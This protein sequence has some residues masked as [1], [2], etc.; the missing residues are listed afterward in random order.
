MIGTRRISH[1]PQ[2]PFALL[3]RS[4]LRGAFESDLLPDAVDIRESLIWIGLMFLS[5]VMWLSVGP[6]L[7]KYHRHWRIWAQAEERGTTDQ[8]RAQIEVTTWG[9][10]LLFVFYAMTAVGFV[11]VLVWDRLYPDRTDVLVLG[12]L[13]VGD[14]TVVG[15]RLTALALLIGAFALALSVPSAVAMALGAPENDVFLLPLRYLVAHLVVV[16]LAGVF[17][18]C[19]LLA[20]RTV[21]RVLVQPRLLRGLTLGLQLLCVVVMLEMLVFSWQLSHWLSDNALQLAGHPVAS[22]LPPFWFLGLYETLLG[23]DHAAFR[24][25]ARDAGLAMVA[26]LGLLLTAYLAS[27]R[28][29]TRQV[30]ETPAAESGVPWMGRSWHALTAGWSPTTGAVV[31]FVLRTMARSR[32]HQLIL[33]MYVGVALAFVIGGVLFPLTRGT[34]VD[35]TTPTVLLLSMP[36]VLSFFTLVGLRVLFAMP[37]EFKANWVFR[38]TERDEKTGYRNGTRVALWIGLVPIVCLTLPGYWY[39]WGTAVAF[40][41]TALWLLLAA[42]LV[43]LLLVG[44]HRIPFA[45]TYVPG[46]ANFK[47]FGL[48][49]LLVLTTYAYGAAQ[50]ELWLLVD[51]VRWAT[52]MAALLAGLLW[53]VWAGRR[54]LSSATALTFDD[55]PDPAVQRLH[56]MSDV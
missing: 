51:P 39:L 52:A 41:H 34:G 32:R 13:P 19:C 23:T 43:E 6:A 47:L 20:A 16:P 28:R 21:L 8:L 45:A 1:E 29:I 50:A 54:R 42:L 33:S 17:S 53:S 44:F 14:R 55:S 38:L 36:L 9:D 46:R 31:G 30:T 12:T 48:V 25:L 56:L 10:E 4:F 2:T 15:A 5:P 40:G 24:S 11:T 3:V 37:S 26:S 18:A 27:Y 35:L 22:W 49:Y 7:G